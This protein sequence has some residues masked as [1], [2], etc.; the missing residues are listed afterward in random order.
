KVLSPLIVKHYVWQNVTVRRS[1]G[2]EIEIKEAVVINVAKI[3]SHR[4]EHAVELRFDGHIAK[5][6][7]PLIVIKLQG[8][9]IAWKAQLA[10][11]N[12]FRGHIVAGDEQVRPPIIIVVKEPGRKTHP[13]GLYTCWLGHF[14]K[15]A[16]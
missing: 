11:Q 7:V 1:A 3:G 14:G 2:T 15:S 12:L 4:V 9:H 16:V 5:C 10:S 6:P 13:G 8:L